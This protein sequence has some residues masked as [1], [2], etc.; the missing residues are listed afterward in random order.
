MMT[1]RPE[2]LSPDPVKSLISRFFF[3]VRMLGREAWLIV[4]VRAVFWE[5]TGVWNPPGSQW[6]LLRRNPPHVRQHQRR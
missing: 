4:S 3:V 2:K 6:I 1:D 5:A